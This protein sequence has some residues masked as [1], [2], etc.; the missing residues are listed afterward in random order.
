[1][2]QSIYFAVLQL[3]EDMTADLLAALQQ[4]QAAG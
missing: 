3:F 4:Y 2:L 1:V